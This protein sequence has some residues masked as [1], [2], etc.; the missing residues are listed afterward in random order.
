VTPVRLLAL[1]LATP[2]TTLLLIDDEIVS[3]VRVSLRAMGL[4]C[5]SRCESIAAQQILLLSDRLKV[6]R[7]HTRRIA[8]EMI[9]REASRDWAYEILVGDAVRPD[10][11]RPEVEVAI[12]ACFR[13]RPFPAFIAYPE[14][15]E[16]PALIGF[17]KG[18]INHLPS[19]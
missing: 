14:L 7:P 8:T 1:A 2:P 4:T 18:E 17:S 5:A 13:S 15:R 11:P 10:I 16:E 3:L 12:T 9:E 6:I 19:S